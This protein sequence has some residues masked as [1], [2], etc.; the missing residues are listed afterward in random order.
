MTYAQIA[1]IEGCSPMSAL[2]SVKRAEA[3]IREKM[4]EL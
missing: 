3:A 4:K 1:D 2:R